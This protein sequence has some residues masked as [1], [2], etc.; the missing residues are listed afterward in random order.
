MN[1]SFPE[2]LTE[3]ANFVKNSFGKYAQVRRL[4]DKKSDV[5]KCQ[6]STY[7]LF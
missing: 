5:I 4:L 3:F 7:L 2:S 6:I 1:K